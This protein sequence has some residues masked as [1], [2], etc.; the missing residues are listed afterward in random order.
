MLDPH[1]SN[2]ILNQNLLVETNYRILM[3]SNLSGSQELPLQSEEWNGNEDDFYYSGKSVQV[4]C[5]SIA[6]KKN[7][8]MLRIGYQQSTNISDHGLFH[9]VSSLL[10]DGLKVTWKC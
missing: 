9:Q 5:T 10:W 8:V 3:F 6:G 2:S 4:K 1:F 7:W